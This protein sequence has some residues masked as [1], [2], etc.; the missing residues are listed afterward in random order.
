MERGTAAPGAS[1]NTNA[2][3][4]LRHSR[5]IGAHSVE[6]ACRGAILFLF[7]AARCREV[8]VAVIVAAEGDTGD[9]LRWER[10]SSRLLTAGIVPHAAGTIPS[11][12]PDESLGI[13]RHAIG[14]AFAIRHIGEKAAIGNLAGG[15]VVV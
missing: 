6:R 9:L 11:R 4:K 8:H 10:D 3:I 14:R 1:L 13:D 12:R 5:Y 7:V 2:R 15:A